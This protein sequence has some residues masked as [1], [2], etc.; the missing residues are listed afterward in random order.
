MQSKPKARSLF[1]L[2]IGGYG[3][4]GI[5]TARWSSADGSRRKSFAATLK[6]LTL[7]RSKRFPWRD[8]RRTK[9]AFGYFQYNNG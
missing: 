9:R 2:A 5:I 3:L 8:V 6:T 7:A 4:F 1:S